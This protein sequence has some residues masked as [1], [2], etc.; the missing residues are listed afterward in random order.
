MNS[1]LTQ[2]HKLQYTK[3]KQLREVIRLVSVIQAKLLYNA[4]PNG[5]R[6]DYVSLTVAKD[7]FKL[8]MKISSIQREL[9]Q[10]KSQMET[11]RK[12]MKEVSAV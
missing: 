7:M 6:G 4:I 3:K 9:N 11:Y 8:Q 2:L 5:E 10:G 12:A 1:L